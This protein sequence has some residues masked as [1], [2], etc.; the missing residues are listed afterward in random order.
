VDSDWW[1]VS[2]RELELFSAFVSAFLRV[3]LFASEPG[4]LEFFSPT[5]DLR[6]LVFKKQGDIL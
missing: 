2:S 6:P 5:P 1:L 3:I 4:R